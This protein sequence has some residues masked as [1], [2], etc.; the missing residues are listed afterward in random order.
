MGRSTPACPE[1]FFTSGKLAMS[2]SA[3]GRSGTGRSTGATM[4]SPF[5]PA[6]SSAFSLARTCSSEMRVRSS[7]FSVSSRMPA[8]SRSFTPSSESA[9]SSSTSLAASAPRYDFSSFA[10]CSTAARTSVTRMRP[11][12]SVSTKARNRGSQLSPSTGQAVASHCV[13]GMRMASTST[14]KEGMETWSEPP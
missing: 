9:S 14:S 8:T 11:F 2:F 6:A 1:R 12:L 7:T 4:P 13:S 3:R 5:C 10:A